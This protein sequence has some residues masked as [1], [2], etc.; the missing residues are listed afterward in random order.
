MENTPVAPEVPE[1][2]ESIKTN[3]KAD[4]D[5]RVYSEDTSLQRVV[6]HYRDMR[7]CHT[8]D[9]YRKMEQKYS[10]EGGKFRKL[11]TIEE[12]FVELENYVVCAVDVDPSLYWYRW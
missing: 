8:V 2:F 10:F 5:F 3:D 1:T 12:A 4:D 11:M 6:D 9:F 7:T